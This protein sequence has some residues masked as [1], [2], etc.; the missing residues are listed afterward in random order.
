[1]KKFRYV[2]DIFKVHPSEATEK[3]LALGLPVEYQN[4]P[5]WHKGKLGVSNNI[6]VN[7][8]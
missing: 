4:L 8:K 5:F 3:M 2:N 6:I 1:M 7:L